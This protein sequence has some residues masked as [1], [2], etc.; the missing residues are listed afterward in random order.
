MFRLR[1]KGRGIGF[2]I[3][4]VR[5]SCCDLFDFLLA[6]ICGR[7]SL[8]IIKEFDASISVTMGSLENM[9]STW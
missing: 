2:L 3:L 4:A 9:A 7:Y 1:V 8:R 5:D 6:L